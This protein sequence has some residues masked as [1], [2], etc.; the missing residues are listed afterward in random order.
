MRFNKAISLLLFLVALSFSLFSQNIP[1]SILRARNN[2]SEDYLV[3]IGV[4]KAKTDWDSMSLAETLARAELAGSLFQEVQSS[5][6]EYTVASELTGESIRFF[7]EITVSL[8]TVHIMGSWIA[9]LEKTGDETWWC[10]LYLSKA[11]ITREI[12]QAQ[13][14]ARLTVPA[15][16][17]FDAEAR[18]NEAFERAFREKE[19]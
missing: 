12:S 9:E 16:A 3:G 17:T 1:N 10:V 5:I 6:R 8:S 18:M 14:A 11:D 19:D 2:A 4:A 15:F 7:E 13:A